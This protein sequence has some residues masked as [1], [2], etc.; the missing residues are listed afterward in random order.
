MKIRGSPS[1]VSWTGFMFSIRPQPRTVQTRN[2]TLHNK[3]IT[4]GY[5]TNVE[6]ILLIVSKK[7]VNKNANKNTTKMRP[8]INN[9]CRLAH[10]TSCKLNI[11]LREIK[12][13]GSLLISLLLKVVFQQREITV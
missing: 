3:N 4:V 11:N 9:E 2:H 7:N 5:C 13:A 6:Y 12:I 8:W 1:G 10:N